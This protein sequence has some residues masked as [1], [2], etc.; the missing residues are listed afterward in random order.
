MFIRTVQKTNRAN[1]KRYECQQ[2]VESIRT[3]QG[4]RQ[5]LLLSLGHL[6]LSS[7]QWPRLAKRIEAILQ[8][9][10]SFFK[11]APEIETFAHKFAQQIIA[12]HALDTETDFFETVDVTSLQNHRVRRIGGEY[13]GA[14]FFNKLKL[15]E[16]LKACGFSQRQ[17]EIAMLLIVGRLVHPGSERHLFRWVQHISGLDELINTDFNRLSLNSLYTVTDLLYQH[18]TAIEAHL[19]VR[20]NDLFSLPETIILYDLTNTYFEGRAASNPKAKFGRSK[21]KRND[22]RLLTLGLV[23][24]S[25]GFPK[26]SRVFAGNQSEPETLLDMVKALHQKD[27]TNHETPTVVIDAGIAT[28]DNLKALK[29]HYHYIAVS[30]KKIGPPDG[31]DCIVIKQT[32]QNKVEATR[33]VGDEEIFLYC[34][35]HLK[36]KK[37]QSMKSRLEQNFQ[38][39]LQYIAQSI[40]NKGCTKRYDKVLQRIGRLKEK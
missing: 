2:L 1:S 4:V 15:H 40:H 17:I 35:S 37:E 27:P 28:D 13:L 7:E 14:T 8:G 9:Q 24:D 5:K 31:D 21:E 34:N 18:K 25:Q 6:P 11:E 39:Q 3:E 10:M 32:K 30:R 12:K 22:C 36:K 29:G 16:C 20:E 26:T 19:R 33:I 38:E 23:I